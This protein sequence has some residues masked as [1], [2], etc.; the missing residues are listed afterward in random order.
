MWSQVNLIIFRWAAVIT[1]YLD[2]K[3]DPG[4]GGDPGPY[5]GSFEAVIKIAAGPNLGSDA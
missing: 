2:K 1:G 4:L 5:K 3:G